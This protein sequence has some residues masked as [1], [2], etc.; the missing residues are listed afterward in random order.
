MTFADATEFKGP[1]QITIAYL[2]M[3]Y[4]FLYLGAFIKLAKGAS[5]LLRKP[6]ANGKI[7]APL[8]NGNTSS[9]VSEADSE[10]EIESKAKEARLIL[11]IERTQGN[12]LEQ[13]PPFLIAL[14]LMTVFDSGDKARDFG[15]AYIVFRFIYPICFYYG[16]PWILISTL[17][18]YA[19]IW[20]ML[21]RVA[22][23][24]KI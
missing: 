4:I 20:A 12:T 10:L 1:I 24:A 7:N 9:N 11:T 18:G 8:V 15:I 22:K 14:W 6:A 5:L 21:S 2:V 19:I 17:P 3:Y 13:M 23:N 16:L